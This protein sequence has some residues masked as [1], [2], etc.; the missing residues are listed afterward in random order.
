MTIQANKEIGEIADSASK[1][2]S[3][4]QDLNKVVQK[5][6]IQNSARP[7]EYAAL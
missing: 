6:K 1:L 7:T 4:M 5:F 2:S 3:R